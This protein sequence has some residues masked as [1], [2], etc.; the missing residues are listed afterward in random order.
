[1]GAIFDSLRAI[2]LM[3]AIVNLVGAAVN[4]MEAIIGS[5]GAAISLMGAVVSLMEAAHLMGVF[6]SKEAVGLMGA[7]VS[8]MGA[9]VRGS[10]P[11]NVIFSNGPKII[12]E[13][14]NPLY[15]V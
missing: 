4:L 8:S 14:S 15:K 11:K 1:M 7:I 12:S 2:S 5:M 13:C 3:E 9:V 10:G 6:G